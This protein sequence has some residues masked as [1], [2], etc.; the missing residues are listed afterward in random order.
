[1]ITVCDAISSRVNQGFELPSL[2]AVARLE[3]AESFGD[4]PASFD[5]KS[6]DAIGKR[7]GHQLQAA[8]NGFNQLQRTDWGF[9]IVQ[10]IGRLT[11]RYL[12]EHD[13]EDLVSI[14]SIIE[15]ELVVRVRTDAR[16]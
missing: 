14:G 13:D 6:I 2:L 16:R 5:D 10:L 4:P 15:H 7:V 11:L 1:M 12:R 9:P 3:S 8:V